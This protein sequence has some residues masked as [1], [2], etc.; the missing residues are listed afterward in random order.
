MRPL[1][2]LTAA[3]PA[4]ALAL[5]CIALLV[6]SALIFIVD[7]SEFVHPDPGAWRTWL[8]WGWV[9]TSLVQLITYI[10][11]ALGSK[12]LRWSLRLQWAL[13][14]VVGN[15]FVVPWFLYCKYTRSTRQGVVSLLRADRSFRT[16][17]GRAA[18]RVQKR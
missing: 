4:V 2:F 7:R 3:L 17:L 18:H 5:G 9:W 16:L 8:G 12:E 15:V 13:W 1:C 10:A 6:W 14:L 11:W